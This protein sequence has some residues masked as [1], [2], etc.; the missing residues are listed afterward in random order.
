MVA[1]PIAPAMSPRKAPPTASTPST[2]ANSIS[3]AK[4]P[5]EA[6]SENRSVAVNVPSYRPVPSKSSTSSPK[7]ISSSVP[8]ASKDTP[9]T[10]LL[11]EQSASPV[12][13]RRMSP[14]DSASKLKR[15]SSV[16]PPR[17]VPGAGPV[18]TGAS[19]VPIS[20]LSPHLTRR[21]IGEAAVLP[22]P[23]YAETTTVP[24][25]TSSENVPSSVSALIAATFVSIH[26]AR[27]N[28]EV[29]RS[30]VMTPAVSQRRMSCS[31]DAYA[32]SPS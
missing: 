18:S 6:S 10:P 28:P 3:T 19:P 12:G 22:V 1:S 31:V 13:P 8:L 2:I 4:V 27:T 26:D 32:G 9:S 30:P 14:V 17:N 15:S 20:M 23:R 7:R 24:G 25:R 16:S 29:P 21:T 5:V 11:I